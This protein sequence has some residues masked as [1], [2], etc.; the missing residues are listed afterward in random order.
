MIVYSG[1]KTEFLHSVEDGSLAD[2]ISRTILEKL[3]R[4]T[5]ENEFRSWQNSLTNMYIVMNDSNIPDNSGVAIEYNIPQTAKRVDFIVS[6]Y[7]A[8]RRP[9]IVIIELKQWEKL[10]AIEG[11]DALVETF[12]GGANRRVVHPSYQAW[13]YAQ[14]IKDY[15]STVQDKEIQIRPCAYL[16]NYERK[17]NDP[18]DK[19]WYSDYLE[20][21]PAFT[22]RDNNKLRE[23]IKKSIVTGDNKEV[24][25]YV[26]NGKIRPS[27]S[28]QNSIAKMLKGNSEFIMIDEQKVVYEDIL[29]LSGLCQKDGRKRTIICQ[30]GPGT[31]KT[32]I[33]VNLLAELTQ[34]NQLV[35][36][37]SKNSA[38]RQVYLKKLKGSFRKSSIDNM[39]K[40]SGT[41]FDAPENMAGTL[42]VDEAH[43]LNEKSGMFHNKGENQIKEIIHASLCSVFFIDEEQ[44]VTMDDI[45]S[46]DQIKRWAQEEDSQIYEMELVS[47]FRCNGSN[48]YLAWLDNILQIRETANYDLEDI[49]FDIRICDTPNEVRDI[50]FEKNR[51][52]NRARILAGYCWNWN[53]NEANNSSYHDIKIGDFEMSWNLDSGEPFAV[54]DTSVNEIGCIHTSQGLE[55]DYVGVII[56]ED[57]RY[58]NGKVITDFTK[59]AG[60]D[61]SLKGIK[62]MSKDNPEEAKRRADEI[63]RNTYRTLLTRG[64][65]GCYIY[66][67]DSELKKYFKERLKDKQKT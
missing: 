23:Y 67:V 47:Q 20:E 7:D 1:I 32:V 55:F 30:G 24:L 31:G 19:K 27:K 3:G 48:G 29:R 13:S 34:R 26:D 49:D 41:F 8:K 45:G 11:V 56:G 40:G 16:H 37:V 38:P 43:R 61:Q 63:I 12:T 62:M 17:E 39:F 15:N 58:E 64:M 52:S 28:L 54:S 60:T 9:S 36:Y 22:K 65:K 4:K 10:T 2:E 25:Y 5:P 33:A 35:Q 53:K 44:R 57:I 51:T 42:L 46:V 59:R 14:L 18:I 66:C 6:G 50:I 21:A